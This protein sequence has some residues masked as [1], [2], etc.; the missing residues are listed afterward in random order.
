MV[1][2]CLLSAKNAP[3]VT[4][5]TVALAEI[6][7]RPVLVAEC[8][9]RYG[10][11]LAGYQQGAGDM[12]KGLLGLAAIHQRADITQQVYNFVQP[13]SPS[14]EARLLAGVQV[15]AQASGVAAL[16]EPLSHLLPSL[17]VKRRPVDVLVDCGSLHSPYA[18]LPLIRNADLVLVLTGD[19]LEHIRAAHDAVQTLTMQLT[20]ARPYADPR[21]R[22]AAVVR[23]PT[24]QRHNSRKAIQHTLE[25][26]TIRGAARRAGRGRVAGTAAPARRV[27]ALGLHAGC[28]G[29]AGIDRPAAEPTGPGRPHRASVAAR[30]IRGGGSCRLTAVRRTR[31]TGSPGDCAP[32]GTTRG[33]V[34]RDRGCATL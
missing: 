22:L 6:W 23:P 3:G 8:D 30:R 15:P 32:V 4:T 1:M 10:D 31:R 2:I 9:P 29:S 19:H 5:T 11:I 24:S 34:R 33:V 16:W 27:P 28:Q 12:T 13:L 26:D 18:P 17:I 20:A 21:W 25:V 14:S 7:P